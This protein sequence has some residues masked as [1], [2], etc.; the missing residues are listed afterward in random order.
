MCCLEMVLFFSMSM[1]I[2]SCFPHQHSFFYWS[3]YSLRSPL[4]APSPH[5]HSDWFRV[6]SW[7]KIIKS[8]LLAL[9][10]KSLSLDFQF[11]ECKIEDS[12]ATFSQWKENGANLKIINGRQTPDLMMLQKRC[13]VTSWA[14]LLW[15]NRAAWA[16]FVVVHL[17]IKE[18]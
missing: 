9:P 11:S 8:G 6:N 2:L 10:E 4:P 15:A 5:T 13:L 3:N 1:R 16:V 7:H 17:W 14:G 12:L 18:S